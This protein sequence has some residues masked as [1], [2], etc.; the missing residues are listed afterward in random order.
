MAGHVGVRAS[1]TPT[2]TAAVRWFLSFS[3][4]TPRQQW[5]LQRRSALA[6][7]RARLVVK[8]RLGEPSLSL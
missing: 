3:G 8:P 1:R 4:A 2:G 7:L 6:Q 5:Q